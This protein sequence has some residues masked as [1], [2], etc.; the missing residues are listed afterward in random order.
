MKVLIF[1]ATGMVGRGV[2]HE[3]LRAPE[4]RSV[5]TIVRSATTLRD[6]KLQEIVHAD[7]RHLEGLQ[8]E[9]AEV[10]ACFFTLGVSVAGKTEAEYTQVNYDLPMAVAE[11]L[12]RV[13]PRMTFVYVSGAGTDSSEKG[14]VLWARV[15]GRTENALLRI[16]PNAYMFRPGVIQPRD[17]IESKTSSYRIFYA[18]SKPLLPLLKAAL[19]NQIVDTRELG[20]AML[21][22][23]RHGYSKRIL[24]TRDIRALVRK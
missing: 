5:I 14:R 2:L 1:G 3:C 7:L 8:S 4:V 15:K 24:E 22:V 16:F 23:T 20:Q 19:P 6:D 11:T 13:N 9:L 21:E 10:D 18:L 12:R 17:G